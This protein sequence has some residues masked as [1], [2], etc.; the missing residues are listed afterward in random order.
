MNSMP[1][2]VT[3]N[4]PTYNQQKYIARA[5]ESCLAQDYPNLEIVVCDDGSS[6]DTFAVAAAFEGPKV[7]VFRNIPNIGRVRNYRRCLYE[8]ARGE[9]AVN[10]DGDDYYDDP[11]FISRA[12]ARIR[13]DPEIVMYAAGSKTLE[14]AT[15]KIECVPMA[16]RDDAQRM[17][18]TDY[19][20]AYH[21]LGAYQHFAVLY[22]RRLA[23]ETGFYELDSLGTDTDSLCRLALRGKVFVERK[24]VGVWTHHQG[25]ASYSLTEETIGKEM[26]MLEHIA[27]ALADHAPEPV[28]KAWLEK[29][30]QFRRRIVEVLM[31]GRL[32]TRQAWAYFWEH[33]QPNLFYAREAVKLVLRSLGLLRRIECAE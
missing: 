6:D 13:A 20:L 18:G 3:I 1:P 4:V 10:L 29:Q 19:V 12:M 26:A 24:H 5:I 21:R 8:L 31:L 27:A 7:R 11:A 28:A 16:M 2:L 9:W 33:K 25:N 14:E 22:D 15:G 32:P 17:D 23:M 30:K